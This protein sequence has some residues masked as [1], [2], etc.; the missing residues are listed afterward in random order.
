MQFMTYAVSLDPLAHMGVPLPK[1]I[2]EFL[3]KG[4]GGISIASRMLF[5]ATDSARHDVMTAVAESGLVVA[6]H[7][8]FDP[9]VDRLATCILAQS[10]RMHVL[11]CG[12]DGVSP[13][14]L[15]RVIES[16]ENEVPSVSESRA[17]AS[18]RSER[19]ESLGRTDCQLV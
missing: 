16:Q 11:G 12:R 13:P 10:Q 18:S 6:L 14:G 4:F 7:G 9:P 1:L 17:P 3:A 15:G 8:S 19:P 2:A 5:E